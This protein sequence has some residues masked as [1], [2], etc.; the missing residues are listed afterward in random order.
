MNGIAK[1][2]EYSLVDALVFILFVTL[3]VQLASTGFLVDGNKFR[4]V[5]ARKT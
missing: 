4:W 2:K 5:S 3:F 1:C